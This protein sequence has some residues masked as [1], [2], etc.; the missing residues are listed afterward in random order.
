MTLGKIISNYRSEHKMSM[1]EFAQRSG[2]SKGYISM[3]EKNKNPNSNKPITP[4]LEMIR[5]VAL[6]MDVDFDTVFS[7]LDKN[8]VINMSDIETEISSF[9][10][11]LLSD[12]HSLDSCGQSTVRYILNSELNRVRKE[13]ELLSQIANLHQAI[14]K[15]IP[16]RIWAYYGKIAAAGTSVEFADM[17]AGTKEYPLTDENRNAD[18]TIGIS[19]DSMEPTFYDGDVVFVKNVTELSLGDIGIFQKDNGI[20]IKEI[21]ADQLISHNPKYKPIPNSS[22]I[23]CLGKVIGKAEQD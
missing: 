21:G 22:E 1:D 13:Q 11:Q 6:G 23:R 15:A 2:I 3:L 5:K 12:F 16:T 10:K 18:Y 20:Y 8:T 14:E 4:T 17:I 7:K 9:D 19:G